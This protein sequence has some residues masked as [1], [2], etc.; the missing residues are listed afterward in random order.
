MGNIT[1]YEACICGLHSIS[2]GWHWPR[3]LQKSKL[4]TWGKG[5]AILLGLNVELWI[6]SKATS[7]ARWGVNRNNNKAS[8][9]HQLQGGQRPETLYQNLHSYGCSICLFCHLLV[10]RLWVIHA[11]PQT[12]SFLS[13]KRG[14]TGHLK[15]CEDNMKL[16]HVVSIIVTLPLSYS[17]VFDIKT[18]FK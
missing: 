1:A 6:L 8:S 5:D 13:C 9:Y 3:G 12:L 14:V 7:K 18:S 15:H 2:N 4:L 10:L 11:I 17:G 16:F